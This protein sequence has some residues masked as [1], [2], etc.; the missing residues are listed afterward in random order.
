MRRGCGHRQGRTSTRRRTGCRR[1]RP[2]RRCRQCWR[3][4]TADARAGY[5]GASRARKHAHPSRGS[6]ACRSRPSRSRPTSPLWSRW[7]LPRCPTGRACSPR[8]S[9]SRPSSSRSWPRSTVACASTSS[10]WP[11]SPA[12]SGLMWTWSRSAPSRWRPARSPI[13]TRSRQRPPSRER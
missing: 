13:S 12:R 8:M 11:S 1:H 9:S 5:S 2:G 10:P 3:I 4:G 7:S 6:S